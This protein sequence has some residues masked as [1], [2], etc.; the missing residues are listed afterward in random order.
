MKAAYILLG[1]NVGNR[2][3][4]LQ[5]AITEIEKQCGKIIQLSSVYETA[6]WGITT[7]PNFYNQIIAI[8]TLLAPEKL[9]QTLLA[10]ELEMGRERIIKY[11]PRIIDLDILFIDD[12][13][14]Q[15][16]T[17]TIPHPAM[18][19]RKFVL[20]PLNEIAPQKFHPVEKKFVCELL[21]ACK[22][23]LNVQKINA[24]Y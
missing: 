8:E 23:D 18:T 6:A 9:M 4:N 17:L 16:P 22:D 19:S 7:Q 11:G 20:I 21:L 10:I 15:T 2:L 24:A 5:T 1:G 3:I 14:I 13:V 12:L